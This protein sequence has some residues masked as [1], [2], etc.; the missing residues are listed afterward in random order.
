M[1]ATYVTEAELRSN[2]GIGSLYTSATVE[3]VCQTAQDLLE[4]YLWHNEAPVVASMVQ[5]NVATLML[6]NPGIFTTGQQIT[7]TNR[8]SPYN[9]T[10]TITGTFPYTTGTTNLLPAI[11]WNWATTNFPNGY[12]FV[13]FAKPIVTGKHARDRKSTR[14]NSSH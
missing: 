10:N 6:A 9:G 8:G 4:K 13:Q 2:L 1:P 12:S 3:E 14:L 5:N 11:Y 7:V